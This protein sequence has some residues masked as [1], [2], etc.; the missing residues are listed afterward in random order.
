MMGERQA[1][2]VCGALIQR[3]RRAGRGASEFRHEHERGTAYLLMWVLGLPL[4][5]ILA[6]AVGTGR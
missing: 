3:A 4:G 6:S 5:I 1:A 2:G